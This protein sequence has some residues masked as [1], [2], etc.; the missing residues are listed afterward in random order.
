MATVCTWFMTLIAQGISMPYLTKLCWVK[1]RFV[2]NSSIQYGLS[3]GIKNIH[4]NSA[5]LNPE[6]CHSFGGGGVEEVV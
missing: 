6:S 1:Y 4:V 3:T 5:I 2:L